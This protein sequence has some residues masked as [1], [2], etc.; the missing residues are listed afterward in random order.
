M[1]RHGM[2][3]GGDG[4][5][6][7]LV[8]EFLGWDMRNVLRT[9]TPSQGSGITYMIIDRLLLNPLLCSVQ[10]GSMLRRYAYAHVQDMD[11]YIASLVKPQYHIPYRLTHALRDPCCCA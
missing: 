8:M 3:R 10:F 11:E 1:C 6:C 2:I 7:L 9:R 4:F 5:D